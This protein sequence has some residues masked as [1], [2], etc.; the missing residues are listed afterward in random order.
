MSKSRKRGARAERYRAY[1]KAVSEETQLTCNDGFRPEPGCD[2]DHIVAVSMGF[3]FFGY[4]DHI[5]PRL[6]GS[7]DNLQSLMRNPN[8]E[9]AARMTTLGLHT[10]LDFF[11]VTHD[12]RYLHKI[13]F[14]AN[15]I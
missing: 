2:V 10:L 7:E 12:E 1:R 4:D 15:R 13:E 8:I 11:L 9:K 3:D 14:Y 6:M 5:P